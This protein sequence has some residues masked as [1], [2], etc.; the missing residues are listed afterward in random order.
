MEE[1]VAMGSAE[2][3]FQY[4][5]LGIVVDVFAVVIVFLWCG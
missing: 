3:L 5:V 1:Q 4:G 2:R